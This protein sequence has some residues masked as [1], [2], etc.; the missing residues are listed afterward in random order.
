MKDYKKVNE[1]LSNLAIL[2]VKLHNLHWNVVGVNFVQLHE[3]TE[4]IYDDIFG[5]YDAVAELLK[6][7]GEMP[8]S[9]VS[10]YLANASIEEVEPKNFS[11]KEVLDILLEDLT[12][13]NDLAKEIRDLADSEGDYEIANEFE[14]HIAGYNKYIWFIGSMLK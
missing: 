12:K 6:M 14:D 13:M 1:Y 3:Y 9:R 10:D 2:N 5:K 8:L 11:A 7:K 4:E